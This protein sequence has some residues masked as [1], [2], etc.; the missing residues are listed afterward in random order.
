MRVILLSLLLFLLS[1]GSFEE[2]S[3]LS[4]DIRLSLIQNLS[5]MPEDISIPSLPEPLGNKDIFY[6]PATAE[7][8][9]DIIRTNGPLQATSWF[10]C[11][12]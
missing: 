5:L 12:I 2:L 9:S 7:K 11:I 3:A 1:L 10:L 6:P 8:K 4:S